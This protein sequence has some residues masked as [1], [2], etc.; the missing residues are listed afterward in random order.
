MRM[1]ITIFQVVSLKEKK[2][3]TVKRPKEQS[4]LRIGDTVMLYYNA[5]KRSKEE[6][7]ISGYIIS[8]LSVLVLLSLKI[9]GHV[10]DLFL[11]TGLTTTH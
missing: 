1:R 3:A 4:L 2:M 11:T 5:D 6:A 9:N 7:A 8:D 10:A